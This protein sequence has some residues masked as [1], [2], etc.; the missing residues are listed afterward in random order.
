M[1][2][3]VS[4][5]LKDIAGTSRARELFGDITGLD[6]H[7]PGAVSVSGT[8]E[9]VRTPRGILVTG[10]ASSELV[11][12]CPRCLELA[13]LPVSV[14]IEEEYVPSIDIETGAL[15][16]LL[17]DVE[18]ELVIDDQHTLDLTQAVRQYLI[19]AGTNSG[20]CREDCKGLCSQCGQN[21]NL[22][23]CGCHT[24]GSDPRWAKLASILA[25]NAPEKQERNAE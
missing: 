14:E 17:D 20:L 21:L 13:A 12:P 7:N 19:V 9:M 18:P 2:Y 23:D 1:R 24:D 5:L 8:I 11:E 6:E 16:P 25:E 3:N 22:G 15:L 4:Q 10:R